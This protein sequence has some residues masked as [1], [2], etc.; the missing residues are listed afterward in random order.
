MS[1]AD[2]RVLGAGPAGLTAAWH[3]ARRGH[4]V[5][6]QEKEDHP[7]GMA[8]S[9]EV[10]GVRVDLGSHRLHPSIDPPLLAELQG[11]L[12]A[13]LQV[14][15]RSGRIRLEGRWIAFP[16]RTGDLLRRL[17]PSFAAGAVRDALTAPWR[18]P[19]ADTFGEV[20]RAGL[21]PT[22]ADAFYGPYA[23][24][25][26]DRDPDAL[27]GELARR[28]IQTRSPL[29]VARRLLGGK[30]TFLYPRRGYGQIS[31]ALADAAAGAGA[32]LRFGEAVT[33]VEPDAG[34]LVWSTLPLPVLARLTVPPGPRTALRSRAMLLV[35]LVLDRPRYTAFDAHYFPSLDV[36]LSRLS[37]PKNYRDDPTDPDDRTVLCAEVPCWAGDELWQ[38]DD[39][40]LGGLVADALGRSDLP[41][42]AHVGVEVRRL[43]HVYPVYELGHEAELANL[44]DWAASLPNLITF[45]RAGLFVPDNAHHAMAMG[46]AAAAALGDDGRFDLAGWRASRESFRAHIVED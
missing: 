22:V 16:L 38:T 12:G 17:S 46:A 30:S 25:L 8:A 39:A 2:I 23:R 34:A 19:E 24:K 26:W 1:G 33:R 31:E 6:V 3:A 4:H 5:I 43:A 35:Y 20:V 11:L 41:A 28:R 44:E 45:G 18:H 21:G 13:D 42:P 37:E 32:D 14:R 15:P 40:G 29:A 10:A 7:G 9:F 27:S 36:P